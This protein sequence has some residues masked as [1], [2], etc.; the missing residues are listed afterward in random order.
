LIEIESFTVAQSRKSTLLV[1]VV[2]GAVGGWQLYRAHLV[3]GRVL[4]AAAAVL[5][6]CAAIPPAAVWFNKRWMT[7][8]AILGYVNSRIIL[9]ALFFLVIA[10]VGLIA[11][12]MGHDPLTRRGAPQ[13][14]YWQKRSSTRQQRAGYERA[15]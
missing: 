8:A 9:S 14:S 15:F 4:L 2:L 12:M 7:L 6:V 1:A 11:R 5:L 3:R 10:P 13:A